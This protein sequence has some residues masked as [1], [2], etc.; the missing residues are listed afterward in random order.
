MRHADKLVERIVFLDGHPN[1]QKV[2]PLKIG[3]N[4]SEVLEAD[5]Q[6]EQSARALYMRAP[7]ICDT[8]EDYVS[9]KL[10]EG[11]LEDEEAHIGFIETQLALI[12]KI[13]VDNYGLLQAESADEKE[14]TPT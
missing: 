6:A 13:G 2:D 12:D 5:L 7:K 9:M 3:Q 11:L 10:F 14:G 8:A 4:I 1:L